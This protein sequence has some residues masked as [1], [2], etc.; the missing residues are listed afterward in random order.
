MTLDQAVRECALVLGTPE[1][2]VR[3]QIQKITDL[4]LPLLNIKAAQQALAGLVEAPKA[5]P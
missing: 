5:M 2:D 4:H 3:Y 1:S